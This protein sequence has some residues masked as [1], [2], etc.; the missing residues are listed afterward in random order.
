MA[1][2]QLFAQITEELAARYAD[3]QI[4][5]IVGIESRGFIFGAPLA[6]ALGVG[7]ALVRKPNK[8]PAEKIGVDYALEYG[9]D[10][11]E[12]HADALKPGQRVIIIDDL[13]ATGGTA[14]AAVKLVEQLGAQVVEVAFIIELAFLEGRAKLGETAAHAVVTY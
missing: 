5:A 3:Q 14:G 8:L 7:M 13:L 9:T 1:D 10:R 11:L 6:N 4:D 2:G 12:M